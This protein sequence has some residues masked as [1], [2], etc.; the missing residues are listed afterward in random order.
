MI[1][2]PCHCRTRRTLRHVPSVF[3]S[4]YKVWSRNSFTDIFQFLHHTCI[5]GIVSLAIKHNLC[6]SSH[7]AGFEASCGWCSGPW[8]YGA[9]EGGGSSAALE[10]TGSGATQ[11]C[12]WPPQAA[13][14]NPKSDCQWNGITDWGNMH[15]GFEIS[16][17]FC[18]C[19]VTEPAVF[20]VL[21]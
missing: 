7:P 16:V 8:E 2:T 3:Y 6:H 10:K 13:Q 12:V 9:W 15:D 11:D 20:A 5:H 21:L 17:F 14:L 4:F 19:F 1:P 18:T